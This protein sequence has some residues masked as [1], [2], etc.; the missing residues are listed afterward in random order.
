MSDAV[1][2]IGTAL[3]E[4]FVALVD[5]SEVIAEV[6]IAGGRGMMDHLA[7][8]VRSVMAEREFGAVAA[9]V[10]PGSFTGIRAG[11]ALAH[12]IA[13][14]RG[15]PVV[16]VTVGEAVRAGLGW[17]GTLWVATDAKRGT[18]FLEGDGAV[19]S[20]L[21]EAVDR[22]EPMPLVAGDMA[23]A[24]AERLGA[25]VAIPAL[26]EA[27]GV[28]RA[29]RARL[30]GALGAMPPLPLYVDAPQTSAPGAAVRPPPA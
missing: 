2:V 17:E 21:L 10:G 20:V 13:L 5:G 1:L 19:R 14:G 25:R 4:V 24:V 15:C 16:G 27:L 26:P 9:L 3:A 30:A 22:P 11:L 28:A 7:G 6:R 12:G 8:A 29:A 18:V 23:A